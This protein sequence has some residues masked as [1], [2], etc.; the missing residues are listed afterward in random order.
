M[1]CI[2]D[3]KKHLPSPVKECL[4][5]G[6]INVKDQLNELRNG[7]DIIV[8]TPHRLEDLVNNS[9]ISLNNCRFFILDEIDAL[10]AQNSMKILSNLHSRMPKMF[11]DGKRLQLVVCSATLHNFEVKKFAEKLM[12][13]PSWVDLKGEDSVP[14]SVHHVVLRVD[15]RKMTQWKNAQTRIKTDGVHLKDQLNVSNPNAETYSEAVKMLKAD[16]AI[17]A[18]DSL[19]IDQA[20]VFCRTKIDCDNM[21]NY[22]NLKGKSTNSRDNPYS[23]VCLHADRSPAERASN[24]E[25]FKRKEVK[26]LICTDVAARGID[27]RGLPF[28]IQ[29]I[30]FFFT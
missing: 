17:K 9:H 8:A 3:F 24:L 22:F 14:D 1:R 7:V 10:L 28:V 27:L 19:K 26:F 11:D 15:P 13:F 2:E 12:Y 6:G 21:E 25:S 16:L 18:I 20:I 29:G 5:L 23:C 30:S 4:I